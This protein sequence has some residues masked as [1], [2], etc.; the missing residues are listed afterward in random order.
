VRS[1]FRGDEVRGAMLREGLAL[2]A[3]GLLY[4]L[5]LRHEEHTSGRRREHRTVVF[6][7]GLASNP[8]A[9][10][11]L[12]TYL[13]ARGIRHQ[14]AFRYRSRG[15]IE[16]LAIDLARELERRVRGGRIDLVAHS[17]G[18]LVAR[19][20]LQ[21]LRGHRRVDRLITLATPH[22]GTHA[23]NFLPSAL[24]RQLLPDGPFLR[25]LNSLE[26]PAAVQT[27]S[28]VA[29]RDVLVQPV[30]AARCPFGDEVRFD[31]LGHV[32]ILFRPEVF[33]EV[34]RRLRGPLPPRG[35]P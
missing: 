13:R 22:L 14:I 17:M 15:S 23:A 18:G 6:V 3:H 25:H 26:A 7:H 35:G 11:P 29:G 12:Q 2:L 8:S 19:C 34:A 28:V 16:G 9:F 32:E 1:D 24:V 10:L 21:Q 5:G 20:Y 4:P 31:E 33:T 30:A 27:T